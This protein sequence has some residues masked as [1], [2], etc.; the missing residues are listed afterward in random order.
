MG[1]RG[2]GWGELASPLPAWRVSG[3]CLGEGQHLPPSSP[4]P[5]ICRAHMVL[6]VPKTRLVR[7]SPS[8]VVSLIA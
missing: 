5:G 1:T 8:I 6:S 2:L 7:W 3:S 4:A